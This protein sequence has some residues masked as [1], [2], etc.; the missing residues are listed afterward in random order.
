M[1]RFEKPAAVEEFAYKDG[2]R[3]DEDDD[4]DDV[5]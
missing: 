1:P 2:M 4:T 5:A 3:D